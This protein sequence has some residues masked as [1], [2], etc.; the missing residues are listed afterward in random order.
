MLRVTL[1]LLAVVAASAV[2]CSVTCQHH[3]VH[4]FIK[5]THD[6]TTGHTHHR[7]YTADHDA[8]VLVCTCDCCDDTVNDCSDDTNYFAADTDCAGNNCE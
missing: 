3:G 2:D 4:N 5:V 8:A 1:L 7:C 6:T